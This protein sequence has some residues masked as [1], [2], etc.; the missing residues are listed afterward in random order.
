MSEPEPRAEHGF[1]TA[2]LADELAPGTL[3]RVR[4]G[5]TFVV[6]ANTDGRYFA[7]AARCTHRRAPLE[8]GTVDGK[9]ITCPWH[10][11]SFDLET[12]DPLALPVT[13]PIRTYPVL[14]S[15]GEVRV[16]VDQQTSVDARTGGIS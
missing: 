5:D 4:I 14:I 15:D 1:V 6:L 13:T 9:K 16:C 10:G 12:G 7:I 3:K 2:A 8:R 11:G